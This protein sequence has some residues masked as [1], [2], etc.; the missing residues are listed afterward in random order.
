MTAHQWLAK[1]M[2]AFVCL[3]IPA[4]LR[5]LQARLPQ[6]EYGDAE[7]KGEQIPAR[8]SIN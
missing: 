7:G 3:Q 5:L 1:T 6:A 8:K 2:F 4:D